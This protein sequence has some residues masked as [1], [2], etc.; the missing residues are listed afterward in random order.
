MSV[1]PEPSFTVDDLLREVEATLVPSDEGLTTSELAERLGIGVSAVRRRLKQLLMEG[2]LLRVRKE[3]QGMDGRRV[4]V[5]AYKLR[6]R[7]EHGDF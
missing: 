5:I 1:K 4:T 3:V 2:R 7:G 6:V